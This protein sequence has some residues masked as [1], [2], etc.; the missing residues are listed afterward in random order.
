MSANFEIAGVDYTVP[1][2]C[3]ALRA[4]LI[5][6]RNQCLSPDVFNPEL[7]VTLSH[8]IGL[9]GAFIM[10]KWPETEAIM[11]GQK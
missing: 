2:N 7:A 8:A 5:D 3:I 10:N 11:R 1:E 6:L 4:N 9:L